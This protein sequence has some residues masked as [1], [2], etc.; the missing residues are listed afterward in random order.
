MKTGLKN[1][2][3]GEIKCKVTVF[4]LGEGKDFGLSYWE[5]KF[6]QIILQ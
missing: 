5:Y 4:D 1:Q 2:V 3:V 6:S